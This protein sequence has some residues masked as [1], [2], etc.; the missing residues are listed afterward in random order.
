M[1]YDPR[2]VQ[3]IQ[4]VIDHAGRISV[5]QESSEKLKTEKPQDTGPSRKD[6]LGYS[7]TALAHKKLTT[8][9]VV[10]LY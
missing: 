2:R 6:N 5:K 9:T 1:E 8:E 7:F 4:N 10:Y 3:I